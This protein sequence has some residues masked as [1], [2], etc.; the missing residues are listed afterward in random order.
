MTLDLLQGEEAFIEL[1]KVQIDAG[2]LDELLG[3]QLYFRT[4]H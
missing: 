2:D 3:N 1:M 4:D